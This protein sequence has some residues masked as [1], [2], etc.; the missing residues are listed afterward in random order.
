LMK[1]AE[2]F[3]RISRSFNSNVTRPKEFYLGK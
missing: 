3:G 2:P 1:Y